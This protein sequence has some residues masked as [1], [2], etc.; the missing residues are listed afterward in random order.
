MAFKKTRKLRKRATKRTTKCKTNRRKRVRGGV[1][2]FTTERKVLRCDINSKTFTEVTSTDE[3]AND[4]MVFITPAIDKTYDD[5]DKYNITLVALTADYNKIIQDS[6]T[7]KNNNIPDNILFM[8]HL[9]KPII[10]GRRVNINNNNPAVPVPISPY[11]N[12]EKRNQIPDILKQ[13]RRDNF[14]PT[15]YHFKMNEYT[16]NII[17]SL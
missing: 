3:F 11:L 4:D 9:A 7:Q 13:Y 12:S 8:K 1:W 10:Q 17:K 14:N 6:I 16:F 2:P 15:Y 5:I